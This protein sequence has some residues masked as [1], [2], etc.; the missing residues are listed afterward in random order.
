MFWI[1][2]ILY[3]DPDPVMLYRSKTEYGVGFH[4]FLLSLFNVH[5]LNGYS[6]VSA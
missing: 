3:L 2:V 5:S 6:I 1:T 4:F